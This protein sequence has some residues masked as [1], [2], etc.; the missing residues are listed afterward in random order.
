MPDLEGN[1]PARSVYDGLPA[2]DLKVD[3]QKGKKVKKVAEYAVKLQKW[4]KHFYFL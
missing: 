1:D 3:I 4:T 2:V